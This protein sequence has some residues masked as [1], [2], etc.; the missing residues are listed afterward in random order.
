MDIPFAIVLYLLVTK[1]LSDTGSLKDVILLFGDLQQEKENLVGTTDANRKG[2][3]FIES[4][5]I[6]KLTTGNLICLML[7]KQD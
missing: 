6:A 1:V 2:L 4:V 7:M 5:R 3:Q